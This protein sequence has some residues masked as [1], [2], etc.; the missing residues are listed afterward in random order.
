MGT[1]LQVIITE[2]GLK[3]QQRGEV[4]KGVPLVQPGDHLFWF[5]RPGLILYLINFVL[6]QVELMLL[7]AINNNFLLKGSEI[8]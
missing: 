1:K 8:L 6:F 7:S 2:M 3:I 5:N 4:L